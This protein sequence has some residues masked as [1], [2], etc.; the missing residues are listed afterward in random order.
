MLNQVVAPPMDSTSN[1]CEDFL[2]FFYK[3]D[4]VPSI[5]ILQTAP[6]Q[7]S[8]IF[9]GFDLVSLPVLAGIVKHMELSSTPLDPIRP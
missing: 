6:T 9:V 5:D 4:I 3:K 7:S 2:N 1:T 8:C